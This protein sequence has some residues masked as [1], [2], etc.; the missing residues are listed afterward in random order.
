MSHH[1]DIDWHSLGVLHCVVE[2]AGVV[3]VVQ[4]GVVL[5]LSLD[6]RDWHSAGGEAVQVPERSVVRNE[7]SVFD[8]FGGGGY[9][10]ED[11]HDDSGDAV[12]LPLFGHALDDLILLDKQIFN[13]RLGQPL[14]GK[15]L[16]GLSLTTSLD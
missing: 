6:I 15:H 2:Q 12:V 5:L 1:L 14:D 16:S 3:V 11:R 10:W 7:A 4:V 8:V 9:D 13:L